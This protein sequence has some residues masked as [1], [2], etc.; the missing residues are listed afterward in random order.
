MTF[1][2][3]KETAIIYYYF[4]SLNKKSMEISTFLRCVLHQTLNP[5]NLLPVVERR[6][7]SLFCSRMDQFEPSI[8]ELEQLFFYSCGQF[9]RAFL[10]IDGL[11]EVNEVEQRNVKSFL[12]E[13]QKTDS[14][15][16]L[17]FTHAAMNMSQVFTHCSRLHITAKDLKDDVEIFIDSQIEKYSRSELSACSPSVLDIIKRKLIADAEGM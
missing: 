16:I 13:V 15:R 3:Q 6:L 4:D 14:V 11:D 8:I 1:S 12:K 17:A 9:K 5:E 10:M 2:G 7:E